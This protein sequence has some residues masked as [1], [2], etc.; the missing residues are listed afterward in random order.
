M[1]LYVLVPLLLLLA[2]AQMVGQSLVDFPVD[3]MQ[4]EVLF[5][6]AFCTALSVRRSYVVPA[7]WLCGVMQDLFFGS[8][9]GASALLYSLAGLAVLFLRG[10]FPEENFLAR[11]GACALCLLVIVPVRP[12]LETGDPR[13]LVEPGGAVAMLATILF[14]VACGPVVRFCLQTPL[15][16]T[17]RVD[18]PQYGLPGA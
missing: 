8:R 2:G 10:R 4:V 6:V 18:K 13:M 16:R 14:T 3:G 7:F 9:L 12:V 15:L 1:R 17:W 5:L 11:W